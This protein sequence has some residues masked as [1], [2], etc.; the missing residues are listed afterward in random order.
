MRLNS[1]LGQGRA[2]FAE[3][4]RR[5]DSARYGEGEIDEEKTGIISLLTASMSRVSIVHKYYEKCTL[6]LE[7]R[8][9][10]FNCLKKM[11]DDI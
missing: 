8:I 4:E 10:D 9:Q 2:D 11:N 3:D 6:A 7:I 1:R 5:L